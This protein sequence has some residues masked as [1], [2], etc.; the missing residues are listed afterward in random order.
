MD[1]AVKNIVTDSYSTSLEQETMGNLFL[2]LE[3]FSTLIKDFDEKRIQY[4]KNIKVHQLRSNT[5]GTWLEQI[6][7]NLDRPYCIDERAQR[8]ILLLKLHNKSRME[9]AVNHKNFQEIMPNLEAHIRSYMELLE[10]SKAKITI[11]PIVGDD[12]V[13]WVNDKDEKQQ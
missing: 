2:L 3:T 8:T 5:L 11:E 1:V 4:E 7:K 13:H 12:R 6:A 10:S 9:I